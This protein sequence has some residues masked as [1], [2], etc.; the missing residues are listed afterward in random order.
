MQSRLYGEVYAWGEGYG[1]APSLIEKDKNIVDISKNYYLSEDGIVRKLEND[2]EIKLSLNEYDPSEPAVLVNEKIMQ[3][4][5]G[6][7]HVLLLGESRK[8]I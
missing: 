1:K 3:I 7:D 6:E 8:S 2:E 4:S 5:E